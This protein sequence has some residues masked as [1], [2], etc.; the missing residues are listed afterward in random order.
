MTSI[1]TT[2][3]RCGDVELDVEVV[4]LVVARESG[5]GTYTFDCPGCKERVEKRAD[6]NA[7]T[8]L[9]SAGVR[10]HLAGPSVEPPISGVPASRPAPPPITADDLIDF[11]F[12]LQEPDWFARLVATS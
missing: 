12:L 6:R 3:P 5:E 2:C 1:R 4:R 7:A 10:V 9:L 8:I 11:H